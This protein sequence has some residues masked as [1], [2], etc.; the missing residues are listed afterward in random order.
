MI[1]DE[2]ASIKSI[3][4]AM[5]AGNKAE[6]IA[7]E[8]EG[9][10][11][12]PFLHALKDAGY[13]YSNK[14]PKGWHYVGEGVE[15]LDKSIFDFHVTRSSLPKKSNSRVVHDEFTPS[16]TDVIPNSNEITVNSP[17]FHSQFTSDEVSMIKDMLKS[18]KD[19]VPV[20]EV[21]ESVHDRIKHLPQGNKTRKTIVIDENIG[22]RLDNFCGVERVNKSDVLNLALIDFL[23]K[24]LDGKV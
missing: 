17:I 5:A 15:P 10:S 7:K 12:K 16:N 19:A 8:I 18:W 22:K 6:D 3:L 21:G 13:K 20:V 1:L 14:V 4:E 11:Q 23:E 24:Y 9:I 2:Q